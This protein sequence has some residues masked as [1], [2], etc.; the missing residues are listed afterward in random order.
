MKVVIL[1]G[2]YGS[3]LSE[4]TET[5]PK[6]MIEIAGKPIVWHIMQ[7]YASY[8]YKDFI[9][10][11]GYKGGAIKDYFHN[12]TRLS[13]DF[14]VS[15]GTGEVSYNRKCREDWNVTLVDT[16][17]DTMTGGRLK[18][19]KEY[20]DTESFMVTYG[21]GVADINIHNLVAFHNSHGKEVT[22]TAVR[23]PTRFGEMTI[24]GNMVVEFAEKPQLAGGWISGGFF[25]MKSS[26]LDEIEG[27]QTMLERE[28]LEMK[29]R[30]G[31]LC[32]YRHDGFWQCMDTKKDMSMLE[33]LASS[34]EGP[35]WMT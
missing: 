17:L 20:I 32:A 13:S 14:T 10:A 6:P 1:A 31:R 34:S 25:V 29:A 28:P 30:L 15:L 16:G 33:S 23:P 18:R 27:D 2:G 26:I 7:R 4:L 11:L 22:V 5:I 3:R 12:F 9:L 35:P 19:L 24:S 21:D 8:G